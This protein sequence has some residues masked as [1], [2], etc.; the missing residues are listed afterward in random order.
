M[1]IAF[2]VILLFAYNWSHLSRGVK[3]LL[4]I[5]LLMCSQ[6]LFGYSL[7]KKRE[8][9]AGAGTLVFAISGLSIGMISQMY[10][11]SGSDTGFYMTWLILPSISVGVR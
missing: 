5:M 2:G 1:V 11:I 6:G 7:W 10:N 8:W 3:T 4:L 9:A